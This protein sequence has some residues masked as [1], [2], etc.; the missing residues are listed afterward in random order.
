MSKSNMFAAFASDSEDEY[1]AVESK[2]KVAKKPQKKQ[3]K[4]DTRNVVGSRRAEEGDYDF[5]ENK[6]RGTRGR[7]RGRAARGRGRGRGG[8]EG[9]HRPRGERG[10]GRGRGRGRGR[11][12]YD[13]HHPGPRAAYSKFA[14]RENT[15]EARTHEEHAEGQEHYDQRRYYDK[16]SGTGH[17]REVKKGGAGKG[18]WGNPNQDQKLEHMDAEAAAVVAEGEADKEE[19]KEETFEQ[20]PE[21]EEVEE[22]VNNL[23]YKEYM[24]QKKAEGTGV[25][26]TAARKPEEI[27][28]TNIQKYQ[29]NETSEKQKRSTIKSHE[30]YAM[31]GIKGDV[32]VG[33]QAVGEEPVESFD[34]R[35]RGRGRGGRGAFRGAPREH[36]APHKP[37]RGGRKKFVANDDE[38]P[39]L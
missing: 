30:T 3:Y 34:R 1:K 15:G 10:F 20:E 33:F 7:G 17:G 11:G 9:E 26:K 2:K 38:F 22:E 16:R 31:S 4:D 24:E 36:Q 28:V 25:K 12:G 8:F 32:E 18:G 39:A 13:A 37:S 14:D 5:S 29:K 19:N 6:P 23:T 21:K 27:K 35:G